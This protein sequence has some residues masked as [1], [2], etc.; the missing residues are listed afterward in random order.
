[1][2]HSPLVDN[3][4]NAWAA[5]HGEYWLFWTF[6]WRAKGVASYGDHQLYQRLYE[7]RLPEVDRVAEII[8][9]VGGSSA[10][11]PAKGMQAAQPFVQSVDKLQASDAIKARVA[12]QTVLKALDAA[13]KAAASTPHALAINN[14]L[15]SIADAHLE[16]VYLL[17]QRAEG[18]PLGSIDISDVPPL[19]LLDR[20]APTESGAST[21]GALSH[22]SHPFGDPTLHVPQIMDAFGDILSYIPGGG[23]ARTAG[24][25]TKGMAVGAGIAGI[26][27]AVRAASDKRK[28]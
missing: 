14:A 6:H 16:A 20:G 12:A 27:L 24:A 23:A 15:S 17:K 25:L 3:L 13:N 1:M 8:A 21:L 18:I 9:A 4:L 5:L 26:V 2:T 22:P 11:D 7:A 19:H 28:R 10:L